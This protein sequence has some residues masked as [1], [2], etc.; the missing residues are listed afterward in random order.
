MK[1]FEFNRGQRDS[2]VFRACVDYDVLG[3]DLIFRSHRSISSAAINVF[4]PS[5]RISILLGVTWWILSNAEASLEVLKIHRHASVESALI[6]L[7]SCLS[8]VCFMG[9]S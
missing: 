6:T 8:G 5:F 3:L 7:G 1:P 4:R 9:R 2:D